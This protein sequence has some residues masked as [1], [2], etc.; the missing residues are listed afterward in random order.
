MTATSEPTYLVFDASADEFFSDLRVGQAQRD[1]SLLALVLVAVAGLALVNHRREQA[2][3]RSE[4]RLDALLHNAHDVV[5]VLDDAGRAGYVSSAVHRLLGVD[6]RDVEGR[7]L[8]DLVHPDDR[9]AVRTLLATAS[10]PGATSLTDVRVGDARGEY[11]WFD[12]DAVDL[13]HH[14][15]VAGV[16][17][18]AHEVPERKALQE[19]LADRAERDPLTGL[20]NRAVFVERLEQ[21]VAAPRPSPFAVLFVDLDRFKAV[22]DTLGHDAG[23]RVLRIIA[24]RFQG[25]VRSEGDGGVGDLVTRLSGDE[26][27]IVLQ[28][29]TEAIARATA[30][31]LIE[32]AA[33]PIPLGAHVVHI[34]ATVGISLSHPQRENPDTTVRQADLAM[35]RAKGAGGGTY[36]FATDR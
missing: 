2:V 28:N 31:R 17:L 22:N 5:V 20:P 30:D 14:P 16:V 34:G 25:A 29:V 35:Y 12:L 7:A 4:G 23:D 10:G 33:L 9:D 27:A 18:T 26:F 19:Q 3:R 24:E 13:R 1:L 21:L 15:E 6:P 11:R 32:V 36:A 8:V